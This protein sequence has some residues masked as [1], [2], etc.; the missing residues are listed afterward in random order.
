MILE[1]G[2]K[3]LDIN[4]LKEIK[5]VHIQSCGNWKR[6]EI[7]SKE[8]NAIKKLKELGFVEIQS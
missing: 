8:K 6:I 3:P 7:K 1:V 5:E 2:E 4:F